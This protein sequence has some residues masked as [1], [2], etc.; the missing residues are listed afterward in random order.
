MEFYSKRQF[1][2]VPLSLAR[3]SDFKRL[4]G[5]TKTIVACKMRNYSEFIQSRDRGARDLATTS[6]ATF[7]TIEG[8]A[9]LHET[10][11]FYSTVLEA[12]LKL[13]FH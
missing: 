2:V 11:L 10:T 6:N 1:V 3:G 7:I 5:G 12:S 13:Q 8:E 9:P 4:S